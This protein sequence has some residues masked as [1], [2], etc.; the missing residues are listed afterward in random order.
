VIELEDQ[1][2]TVNCIANGKNAEIARE[3]LGDEVI[4]VTGTL[5]GNSILAER[6]L[7][8]DVPVNGERKEIDFGIVFISDTHFGSKDFLAENWKKFVR[9]LNCESDDERL[10]EIAERVRYLILA[11]DVVDGV[12][13]YPEQEKELA[14]I[15]IYEQYELQPRLRRD[16]E[17]DRH[18]S[19]TRKPRCSPAGGT[20]ATTAKGVRKPFSKERE[21]R[22][23]SCLY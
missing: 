10:N 9:W 20:S 23:K 14:I 4:G 11:G 12:G 13:V 18:H 2:G 15:D 19:R 3:L 21:M 7:F 17:G 6:I 1:T 22:G 16:K 5:R 8:P